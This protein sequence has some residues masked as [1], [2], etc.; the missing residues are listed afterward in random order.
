MNVLTAKTRT[1]FAS[2]CSEPGT[3]APVPRGGRGRRVRGKAK[4]PKRWRKEFY[5]QPVVVIDAI[6]DIG[7][8][9]SPETGI[10]RNLS[11]V[12]S[13]ARCGK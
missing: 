3:F 9:R 2:C 12:H 13:F 1:L 5:G 4:K 11:S 8:N 6:V 10:S 7:L